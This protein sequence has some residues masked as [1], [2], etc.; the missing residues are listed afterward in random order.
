LPRDQSGTGR[1]RQPARK[2]VSGDPRGGR[3]QAHD[4]P[5]Q[6]TNERKDHNEFARASESF[7]H[8]ADQIF[9]GW[10]EAFGS[11]AATA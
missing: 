9:P 6:I 11:K 3:S 10:R 2:R 7:R 8:D 1:L 5:A 4:A